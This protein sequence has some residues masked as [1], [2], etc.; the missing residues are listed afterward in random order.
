MQDA[1]NHFDPSWAAQVLGNSLAH[2]C[3]PESALSIPKLLSVAL[4]SCNLI[5]EYIRPIRYALAQFDEDI[6][7]NAEKSPDAKSLADFQ[8]FSRS[9]AYQTKFNLD[10]IRQLLKSPSIVDVC[11]S[12]SNSLAEFHADVRRTVQDAT[13]ELVEKRFPDLSHHDPQTALNVLQWMGM[14][15]RK[16]QEG[17]VRV[18]LDQIQTYASETYDVIVQNHEGIR[19]EAGNLREFLRK[20]EEICDGDGRMASATVVE[21]FR[22]VL[23][24]IKSE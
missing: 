12:V 2:S 19:R 1:A 13:A 14:E 5:E 7:K 4:F 6:D 11:V 20:A 10:P 15:D 9:L 24:T 8:F 16:Q 3:N 18:Y 23:H 22:S 21:A 17:I